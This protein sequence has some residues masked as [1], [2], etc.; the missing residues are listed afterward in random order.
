MSVPFPGICSLRVENDG[1]EINPGSDFTYAKE[2]ALEAMHWIRQILGTLAG[3]AF[4]AFQVTGMKGIS[5]FMI[6][7]ILLP[8]TYFQNYLQIDEDEV[9][10]AGSLKTEGMFSSFALFLLFWILFYTTFS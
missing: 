10:K 6:L 2:E 3:T 5:T 8:N 9:A 7:C 1:V 4:G